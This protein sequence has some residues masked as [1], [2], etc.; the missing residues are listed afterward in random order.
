VDALF[1]GR[2]FPAEEGGTTPERVL[3]AARTLGARANAEA[4]RC[5]AALTLVDGVSRPDPEMPFT[6]EALEAAAADPWMQLQLARVEAAC[7]R[8]EAARRRWTTLARDRAD[9]SP[10]ATAI[11]S[12][13]ASALGTPDA[14]PSPARLQAALS[15]ITETVESGDASA[16]GTALYVQA[17]LRAALGH[18]DAARESLARVFLFPDHNLSHA[19]ARRLQLDLMERSK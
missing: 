15:A 10:A 11:A 19:L 18:V 12:E 1:R 14:A 13:A 17:L 7:G 4:H 3:V 16:P 5:D 2:Y 6:A 9:A 8:A